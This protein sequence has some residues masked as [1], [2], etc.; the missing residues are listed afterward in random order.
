MSRTKQAISL[1]AVP[2]VAALVFGLLFR[3]LVKEPIPQVFAQSQTNCILQG[4]LTATGTSSVFNNAA[5]GT[6]CNTWVLTVRTSASTITA[7]SVQ[8]ES[9]GPGSN[10]TWSAVTASGGTS[11]P[12][13]TVTGCLIYAQAFANQF[14]VNLTSLT[15]TGTVTYMLLGTTGVSAKI[16]PTGLPPTG[17]A[18]GDLSGTYP[19]PTVAKIDG[20][21]IPVNSA[22]DQIINT[23]ASQVGQWTSIGNCATALTYSTSTHTFGCAASAG[24]TPQFS[25]AT[26]VT[27][28]GTT[29]ATTLLST[30]GALG[31]LTLPANFFSAT[32]SILR[33]NYQGTWNQG[34]VGAGNDQYNITLGGVSVAT[35]QGNAIFATTA[36][37]SRCS[38]EL[39]LTA[40]AV[41]ASGSLRGIGGQMVCDPPGSG[42]VNPVNIPFIS[43]GNTIN[44]TGT[45]AFNMTVT[46][47]NAGRTVVANN[48][49]LS[50]Y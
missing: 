7:F 40:S 44:T 45:L 50:N 13:T 23:T 43:T 26:A 3:D 20:T 1:G 28:T 18:G 31:S 2:I 12:C 39:I 36:G 34:G 16:N 5:G 48:V 17:A 38:M 41:G 6:N 29:A 15:G 4:S 32:G 47:N 35:G 46:L 8:L 25:Q 21:S 24:A 37:V 11:N 22:A 30:T 42:A 14:R 10:P 33:I 9:A 19:N 49:V 27:V